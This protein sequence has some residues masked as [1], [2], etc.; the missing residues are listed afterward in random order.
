[1]FLRFI[2]SA[3]K[4]VLS[5]I[6]SNFELTCFDTV[7]LSSNL[8]LSESLVSIIFVI[9]ESTLSSNFSSIFQWF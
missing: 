9:L 2:E 7:V 4:S 8:I 3:N 1:M 5:S 6:S